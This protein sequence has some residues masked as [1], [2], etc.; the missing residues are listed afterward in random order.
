VLV[1]SLA[2]DTIAFTR[3]LAQA[4]YDAVWFDPRSGQTLDARLPGPP[5]Q[6][7]RV[8]KPDGREWL[9]LLRARAAGRPAT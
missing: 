3:A 2:G 9:L 4:P 5:G 8:I 1:Y 6:G 7:M